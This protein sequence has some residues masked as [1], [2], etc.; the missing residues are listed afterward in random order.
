MPVTAIY[1]GLRPATEVKRYRID[2]HPAHHYIVAG[3]IRST[4]LTAALGIARHVF[5]LYAS[6]GNR[7]DPIAEP[8]WPHVPNLADH[9]TRDFSRPGHG[10]IICHCESVTRREIEQA[11]KGGLGARDIGGVK[12][13]T[14]AMMGRCQGFY[15]SA[16]VAAIADRHLAVPLSTGNA[17][18]ER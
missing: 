3:G 4:G 12:R 9:E 8:R 11:L 16:A 6:A 5:D 14:R 15:C 2:C 10:E 17:D 13:R 7:H 18:D 1:A